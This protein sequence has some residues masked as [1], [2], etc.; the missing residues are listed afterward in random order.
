[1][2]KRKVKGAAPM[3]R[4]EVDI[5]NPMKLYTYLVCISG[6]ATYPEN[7]R[8]FRQKNLVLTNIKKA[9]GITD[10]TAKL[11]LYQLEQKGLIC[12]KGEIR[13][14]KIT[15]EERK[16]IERKLEDI[17]DGAKQRKEDELIGSLLWTK[18]NKLE[19]MGVYYIPRPDIW[20]PIPEK[21]LKQLNEDFGCSELELKLYL[22]C[23]NYRDM[24]AF[25]GRATKNLTFEMIRDTFD[26]KRTASDT[27]KTIRRALLFLKSIG[28]IDY[29]ERLVN[30][31]KGAAI[32][33]FKLQ[34]VGYYINYEI[35]K[36]N[37]EIEDQDLK[38]IIERVNEKILQG[39][40][41]EEEED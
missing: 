38:A 24:C 5:K 29:T 3:P 31:G 8:M 33:C 13:V 7:T 30:N 9:T 32:P 41:E 1:M 35:Q 39:L 16:E 27:N 25:E 12:Y 6:L 20:T 17:S 21:T 19:K 4:R 22:L 14:D 11:Y 10:K 34:E 28:L 26:L 23:C 36:I 15:D 40:K 18:R 2:N 37:E